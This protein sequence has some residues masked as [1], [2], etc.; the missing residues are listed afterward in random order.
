MEREAEGFHLAVGCRL[1]SMSTL[2]VLYCLQGIRM[3]LSLASLCCSRSTALLMKGCPC[4]AVS[5]L[6][7]QVIMGSYC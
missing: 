1:V 4:S 2:L 5:L 3:G 7:L 6:P